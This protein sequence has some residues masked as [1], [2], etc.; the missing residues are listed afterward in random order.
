[1]NK[2]KE[3]IEQ[4]KA[5]PLLESHLNDRYLKTLIWIRT[6]I[7]ILTPSLVLLIGLQEKPLPS[8]KLSNVLLLISILLMTL[9]ILTGLWVLLGESKAHWKA[10]V[11][12]K[13]WV[14][15]GK[16]ID[17]LPYYISFPWHQSMPLRLFPKLVWLSILFLGSFGFLKYWQF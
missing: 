4:V 11:D 1:M 2:I 17:D 7:T 10:V 15:A 9:S 8:E 14:T 13:E 16:I 6:T 3:A 5:K 12:I